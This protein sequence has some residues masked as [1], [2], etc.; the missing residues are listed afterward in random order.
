[1]SNKKND[2]KLY[3]VLFPFWMLMLFPQLWLIILP[4]NFMIDS[5]VLL[6]SLKLFK[7]CEKKQWYKTWK[8]LNWGE[9]ENENLHTF[10]NDAL[11]QQ[12][13]QEISQKKR[14]PKKQEI[15]PAPE[16]P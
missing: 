3:N 1:M 6:I 4:G 14:Q 11:E 10:A 5:L 7:I 15:F 9:K 16:V 2:I 12:I 13:N 8:N